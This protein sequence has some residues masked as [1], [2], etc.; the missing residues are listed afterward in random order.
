MDSNVTNMIEEGVATKAELLKV[1]VK[2][3][4]AEVMVTKAENGLNL[5]KMA[6]N[7]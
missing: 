1:K 5:S 4:E 6:L 7:Q 2:L 3:N